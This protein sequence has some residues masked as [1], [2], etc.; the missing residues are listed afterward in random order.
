MMPLKIKVLF[1][2]TEWHGMKRQ[3]QTV[4]KFGPP[5]NVQSVQ[6]NYEIALTDVHSTS[7]KNPL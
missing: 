3:Y 1:V 7:V 2:F 5:Y 4:G 6:R